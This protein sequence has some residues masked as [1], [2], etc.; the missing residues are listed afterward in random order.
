[1]SDALTVKLDFGASGNLAAT[2]DFRVLSDG[3]G[4]ALQV[5]SVAAAADDIRDS[6]ATEGRVAGVKTLFVGIH[7]GEPAINCKN[8]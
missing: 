3:A 1:M 4:P 8:H 5:A 2:D 7:E 6:D